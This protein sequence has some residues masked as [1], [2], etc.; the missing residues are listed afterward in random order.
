MLAPPWFSTMTSRLL[1][2]FEA[3]ISALSSPLMSVHDGA[4]P[5]ERSS[6]LGPRACTVAVVIIDSTGSMVGPAGICPGL[7]TRKGREKPALFFLTVPP[8][9]S[10]PERASPVGPRQRCSLSHL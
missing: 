6:S 1:L 3:I 10:F 7:V 9:S 5:R 8:K 2:G 4:A